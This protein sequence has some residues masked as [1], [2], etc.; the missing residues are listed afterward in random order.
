MKGA[1][2]VVSPIVLCQ[3]TISESNVGF[4]ALEVE[5]PCR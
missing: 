5:P 1:L 4:T 2:K 3:S